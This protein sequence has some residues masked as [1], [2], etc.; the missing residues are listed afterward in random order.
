MWPVALCGS[1]TLDD[2]KVHLGFSFDDQE[3]SGG[4]V[5]QDWVESLYKTYKCDN[6]CDWGEE[7]PSKDFSC[8]S[9]AGADVFEHAK[10]TVE[11]GEARTRRNTALNDFES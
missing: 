3:G 11:V 9:T 10:A 4:P 2:A 8:L 1:S 6:N 5:D 7:F